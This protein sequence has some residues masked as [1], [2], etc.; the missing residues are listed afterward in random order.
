MD[1]LQEE[2]AMIG[3]YGENLVLYLRLQANDGE[4]MRC[5]HSPERLPAHKGL[6]SILLFAAL[7]QMLRS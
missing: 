5:H 2:R 6:G 3:G 1:V 4:L 7:A